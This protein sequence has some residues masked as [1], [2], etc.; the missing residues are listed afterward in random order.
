M[1]AT[2]EHRSQLPVLAVRS[3]DA[4]SKPLVDRPAGY[5]GRQLH[6]GALAATFAS[7]TLQRCGTAT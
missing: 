2:V 7:E 1:L 5:A 6:A 3:P 4:C